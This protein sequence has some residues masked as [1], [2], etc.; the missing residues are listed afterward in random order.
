MNTFEQEPQKS[1]TESTKNSWNEY[2]QKNGAS[3]AVVF[4]ITNVCDV[5]SCAHCYVNAVKPGNLDGSGNFMDIATVQVWA[6]TLKQN[7][8]GSPEQI[9]ISGGE[10]TLH[11]DLGSIL[12]LL[13]DKQ[14][15]TALITNGEK[16]ANKEFCER[17]VLDGNLDEVAVTMR[18]EGVLHDLF[19]LPAD[20]GIWASA[21]SGAS[22]KEQI[23]IV[24]KSKSGGAEH[25]EKTM[26]GIINLSKVPGL[27]IGL[28]IDMQAAEDMEKVVGE[29]IKRG[30]RVDNIYLQAQQETGRAKEQSESVPN[31]WRKPT[32]DITRE[33]VTQS[34]RLLKEKLVNK[35]VI[36][37]PL[38]NE[39]VDSLGL[40]KNPIYQP[41]ATPAI[42]PRGKLRRDVLHVC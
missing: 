21:P 37:D 5:A 41:A 18:G 16:L 17:L 1:I 6:E 9:W 3:P 4:D 38:S 36:I 23:D 29:I 10:P 39:I 32:K 19:M 35:I 22:P 30:G 2:V 40:K 34:E 13:K 20:D 11:K 7:T 42:S 27:K 25:F 31:L 33:Y 15:Y 24:K 28:N 26:K 12:K 14:F 8:E